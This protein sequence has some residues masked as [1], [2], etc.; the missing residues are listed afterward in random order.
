MRDAAD[1]LRIVSPERIRDEL[2]KLLLAADPVA[3]LERMV[4]LGIADIVLPEVPALRMEIDEHHQHKDV[5]THTLTVLRQAMALEEPGAAPDEVLRWAALLHDIGKP[6]TRRHIPGGGVSFHHHEVVGRDM[7]RKRLAALRFPKDV[8][9]AV[10]QLVYLHLRFHGYGTGEWT[11]AAVRRY[12]HDAGPHLSRLHKL[13]RS[14]CT[15]RN[16]RKAAA[17]ERSYDSLEERIAALAARE[18]IDAIR[19]ELSGDDIMALLGLRPS[20]L[21]G[22]ARAHMLEF[23]FEHGLVGRAAA[24][25]ELFRWARDNGVPVP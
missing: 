19:P 24:E 20:K 21:V 13:V 4:G 17:L 5:Y 8:A 9:D 2:R 18:E 3:G 1:R 25:A 15:T 14:D 6:R 16:R 23:R 11:D 12:V 22:A 10:C 7:T